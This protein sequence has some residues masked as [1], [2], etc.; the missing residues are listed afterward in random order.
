VSDYTIVRAA[1]APDYTGDAPGAFI[2]YGRPLGAEQLAV[3]LR[4]SV[5]VEDHAA[6]SERHESFWPAH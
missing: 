1:E 6:E 5:R 4:I 2:G 3:N